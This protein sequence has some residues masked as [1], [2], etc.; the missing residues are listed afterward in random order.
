MTGYRTYIVMFVSAFLVP[1]AAQHGLNLDAG[2]QAWLV[3]AIMF[4]IAAV[5][6]TI[7]RTPPLQSKPDP[8]PLPPFQ[9]TKAP[10]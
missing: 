7:T 5:M 2:Q 10:S 8:V 6:R 9:S 3:G 4:V 1:L